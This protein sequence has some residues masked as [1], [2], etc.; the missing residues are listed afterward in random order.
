M[1]AIM[2]SKVNFY[3]FLAT[4]SFQNNMSRN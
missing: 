3:L 1:E 2:G 4:H